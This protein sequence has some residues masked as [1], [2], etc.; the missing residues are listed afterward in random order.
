[1]ARN[2]ITVEVE[3]QRV[4]DVLADPQSYGYWVVGSKEIRAEEGDFPSPG[5]R[6]HH[7]VGFGP[8][9]IADHTRV[10]AAD[11]PHHLRLRAR[12]RPAG[13]AFVDLRMQALDGGRTRIEMVEVAADPLTKLV[14]NRLTDFLVKGRN[15]ESLRRLKQLAERT[16]TA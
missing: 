8:L 11:P 1:M 6:F 5:S 7:K 4:W 3:P 16:A 9:T 15:V 10:E 12:A 13:T 14:F 2:E